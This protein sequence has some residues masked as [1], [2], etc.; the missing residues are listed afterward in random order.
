[1]LLDEAFSW[2]V[3]FNETGTMKPDGAA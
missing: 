1:M 2:H 3:R